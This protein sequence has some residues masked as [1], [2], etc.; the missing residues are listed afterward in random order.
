MFGDMFLQKIRLHIP[1][2]AIFAHQCLL[3]DVM[4]EVSDEGGHVAEAFVANVALIGRA[5]VVHGRLVVMQLGALEES[6]LASWLTANVL[7]VHVSA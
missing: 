4:V 1:F 5:D 2:A 3:P 7:P 6:P